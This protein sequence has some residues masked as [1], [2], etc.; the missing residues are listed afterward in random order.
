MTLLPTSD[1]EHCADVPKL[2]PLSASV[3]KV[4]GPCDYCG[5][6]WRSRGN[7]WYIAGLFEVM[8]L[9]KQGR[10]PRCRS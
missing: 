7:G 5:A 8:R 1:C 2:F 3:D 6:V 10:L 9:R 4:L